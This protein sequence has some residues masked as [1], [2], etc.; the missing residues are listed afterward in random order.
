MVLVGLL[1][2][3]FAIWTSF[4]HRCFVTLMLYTQTKSGKEQDMYLSASWGIITFMH[5]ALEMN[6]QAYSI[7]TFCYSQHAPV[8]TRF[9]IQALLSQS[10]IDNTCILSTW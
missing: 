1:Y 3:S 9:P 4:L 7:L 6:K 5:S 10:W 8:F 2:T